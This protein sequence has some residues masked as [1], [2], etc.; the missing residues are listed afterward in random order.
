MYR[1][2]RFQLCK[3]RDWSGNRESRREERS[4]CVASLEARGRAQPRCGRRQS[5]LFASLS[6]LLCDGTPNAQGSGAAAAPSTLYDGRN[7][8]GS[9]E[10]VNGT[11]TPIASLSGVPSLRQRVID[12]AAGEVLEVA[13]G[14]G[15][16]IPRYS[17]A[18]SGRAGLGV[19]KLIGVDISRAMLARADL[20]ARETSAGSEHGLRSAG[21]DDG[22]DASA[23]SSS[24]KIELYKAD[25]TKRLPFADHS[26][27]TVIDTFGLCV[28]DQPINALK[29]MIRVLRPGGKLLVSQSLSSHLRRLMPVLIEKQH[30]VYT[31]HH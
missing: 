5:V 9:Y 22:L 15:I 8:V 14:S 19:S 17:F 18:E 30:I 2:Y 12:R 1:Q 13:I 31:F 6:L 21:R 16:N 24:S 10:F 23:P 3:R 4:E 7:V 11:D 20:R 29:E 26:F 28:F 27:D 25:V